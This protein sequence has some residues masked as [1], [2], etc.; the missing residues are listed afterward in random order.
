MR[1]K[2]ARE[3]AHSRPS[4]AARLPHPP[5]PWARLPRFATPTA[6]PAGD[7]RPDPRR[8]SSLQLRAAARRDA[9]PQRMG[10]VLRRAQP[11]IEPCPGP[12]FLAHAI[13]LRAA[14]WLACRALFAV[15][16]RAGEPG[17]GSAS[18]D[19]LRCVTSRSRGGPPRNG[20]RSM[21]TILPRCR[22][23]RAIRVRTCWQEA[24][25]LAGR[26]RGGATRT[27]RM[28]WWTVR[29][30]WPRPRK[31]LEDDANHSAKQGEFHSHRVR[32]PAELRCVGLMTS[33][34]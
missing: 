25:S 34:S 33:A 15:F 5:P 18:S 14:S 3:L 6:W 28:Y 16:V 27:Q 7:L 9:S 29:G 22:I 1:C 21:G 8:T 2:S 12:P 23:C 24:P 4:R 10:A 30:D 32:A 20:R 19:R 11:T 31:W 13:P 17:G 26:G